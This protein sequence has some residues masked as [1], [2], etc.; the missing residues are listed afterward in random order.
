ME[1][2]VSKGETEIS[3]RGK[4]L[5]LCLDGTWNNRDDNTNVFHLNNLVADT[6]VDGKRQVKQYFR[7]VGTGLLDHVSGGVFGF[8]LD[9]NIREAYEW[10][11]ENYEEG[12]EIFVFGFS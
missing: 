12:D 8:G 6:G 2:L 11:I 4:R 1:S 10:L 5:V 9:Q 7:G 3:E